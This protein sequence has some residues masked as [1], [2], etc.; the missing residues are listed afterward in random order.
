MCVIQLF[1]MKGWC[2]VLLM[3]GAIVKCHE[4]EDDM[5]NFTTV[6]GDVIGTINALQKNSKEVMKDIE[7]KEKIFQDLTRTIKEKM[8]Y[9]SEIEIEIQEIENRIT[10]LINESSSLG[11]VDQSKPV[12]KHSSND[13]PNVIPFLGISVILNI[14]LSLHFFGQNNPASLDKMDDSNTSMDIRMTRLKL[15]DRVKSSLR[16]RDFRTWR[17][18]Q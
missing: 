9:K 8:K 2:V 17:K 13:L 3:H 5:N 16:N 6:V 15:K 1:N 18:K 4:T 10:N 7:Q 12:S 11:K 14:F